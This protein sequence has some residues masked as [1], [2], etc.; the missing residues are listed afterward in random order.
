MPRGG[1]L[2]GR[3]RRRFCAAFRF[4]FEVAVPENLRHL[5]RI[6]AESVYP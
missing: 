4:A 1:T 3:K 2:R 6:E 5:D